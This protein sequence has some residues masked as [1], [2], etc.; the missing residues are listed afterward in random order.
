MER[1]SNIFAGYGS[2]TFLEALGQNPSLEATREETPVWAKDLPD[3]QHA[4]H[5]GH[6]FLALLRGLG[7]SAC[8]PKRF[9]VILRQA[10]LDDHAFHLSGYVRRDVEPVL[11][12]LTTLFL[13]INSNYPGFTVEVNNI[14]QH[15][16]NFFF[17]RFLALMPQLEHFRLNCHFGF[18]YLINDTLEWLASP[19]SSLIPNASPQDFPQPPPSIQ[20]SNL[21]QLDIGFLTIVPKHLLAL[22]RKYCTT[23]QTIS[24][25]KISLLHVEFADADECKTNLWL[26]F[27]I[28]LSNL[29]LQLSSIK[30]S[31]LL[32]QSR[33]GRHKRQ[34]IFADYRSGKDQR[35]VRHWAGPDTQSGLRD[36]VQN[37]KVYMLD[38]NSDFE[39]EGSD[40]GDSDCELDLALFPSHC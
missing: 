36:F 6:I 30:L 20:F 12:R 34:V 27:F 31:S 13:D 33:D 11:A 21:H 26:D 14:K 37:I 8:R 7:R 5:T 18:D 35:G 15:C 29:G 25:H 19:V 16:F 3:S 38:Y 22:I 9:E 1:V 23:L 4:L 40:D 10:S 17:R 24:F 39:S 2:Q 32:Q 28:Q